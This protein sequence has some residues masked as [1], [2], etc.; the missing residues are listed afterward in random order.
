MTLRRAFHVLAIAVTLPACTT[1]IHSTQIAN[2]ASTVP[3]GVLYYLPATTIGASMSFLPRTCTL[4][5]EKEV[6]FAYDIVDAKVKHSYVPDA[7]QQ[8]LFDYSKLN[9]K[10]KITSTSVELYGSGAIKS[11]NTSVD[12]RTAEVVGAVGNTALNLVKAAAFVPAV[13]VSAG[14]EP[15]SD[16][17]AV[18][19]RHLKELDT[20]RDELAK[21]QVTDDDLK[22]KLGHLEEAKAA[23]AVAQTKAAAAPNDPAA[24]ADVNKKAAQVVSLEAATQGRKLASP[25]IQ[26]KIAG[27]LNVLTGNAILQFVPTVGKTCDVAAMSG[28]SYLKQ[29]IKVAQPDELTP[30]KKQ[31]DLVDDDSVF[32][33]TVC[34]KVANGTLRTAQ[35]ALPTKTNDG[36]A[37]PPGGIV[38][39]QPIMAQVTVSQTENDVADFSGERWISVPQYGTM[40]SLDLVNGP[41]DNNTL[42]LAFSEDGAL[43]ALSFSAQS[44]A[45]NGMLT[46]ENLSKVYLEIVTARRNAEMARENAV[47]VAEKKARAD[48]IAKYDDELKLLNS[49]SAVAA[50]LL[51]KDPLQAEIDATE[52][53]TLLLKKQLERET[54]RQELA[55]LK[56]SSQ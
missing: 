51:G 37:I 38:Y 40:A 28:G 45:E 31:I 19:V 27:V 9:S 48:E 16:C 17:P 41:F 5:S 54:A 46:A 25:G 1:A 55:R 2:T 49:K 34:V 11:I 4:N 30:L 24:K 13:A 39:R 35:Q 7:T 32:T 18:I 53:E 6:E 15:K 20:L 47:D 52:L 42:K 33:A 3:D 8:Y 50:K 56:E 29:F 22:A 26:K 44:S 21:A 14:S 12:D 36:R 43:S 10:L 23:L